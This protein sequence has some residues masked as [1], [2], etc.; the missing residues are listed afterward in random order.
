[1]DYVVTLTLRPQM[2]RLSAKE[3][4]RLCKPLLEKVFRKDMLLDQFHVSLVA[5]LTQEHNIHYH[6][7]VTLRSLAHKDRL[8]DRFRQYNKEFGKKE[9]VQMVNYHKWY[10]YINKDIARTRSV[11]GCD[12]VLFNDH[13]MFRGQF[14][15]DHVGTSGGALL[16]RCEQSD[17]ETERLLESLTR[18]YDIEWLEDSRSGKGI[19]NLFPVTKV[20]LE[21]ED[22][23]V[24]EDECEEPQARRRRS[25]KPR[26]PRS[27]T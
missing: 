19:V 3:Q 6:G 4:F 1:M 26:R 20:G 9:I 2:Y 17:Q 23:P 11:I 18:R 13:D 7:V 12:P 21:W 15:E 16:K 22:S 5:E 10:D 8:L 27:R 25:Q 14:G 24:E